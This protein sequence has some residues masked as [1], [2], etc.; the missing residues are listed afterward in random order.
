MFV[1]QV[2]TDDDGFLGPFFG[3]TLE[4]AWAQVQGALD[5]RHEDGEPII[6]DMAE[7]QKGKVY[8]KIV[9][10]PVLTPG[11]RKRRREYARDWR[12][13]MSE[14]DRAKLREREADANARY[15]A[16]LTPEQREERLQRQR[17]AQRRYVKR[18][19]EERAA[20]EQEERN[21]AARAVPRRSR[22]STPPLPTR[23]KEDK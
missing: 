5:Q 6:G 10:V 18:K 2:F 12:K 13:R 1:A 8:W 14:E 9:D 4:E 19:K 16:G 7:G 23:P 21:R 17:E 20:A 11:L 3:D 22:K 15:L